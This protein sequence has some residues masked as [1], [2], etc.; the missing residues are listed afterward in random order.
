MSDETIALAEDKT[1]AI[2]TNITHRL[3]LTTDSVFKTPKDEY[4]IP[5]IHNPIG[6]G[7]ESQVYLANR[8]SDNAQV[9]IKIYDA[10]TDDPQIR[11]N[12]KA[13]LE[14]LH[15][16]SDYKNTHIMPL[17]DDG[18]VIMFDDDGDEYTRQFD[19]LPYC[20]E[21]ELKECDYQMLKTQVIP[22]III[23]LNLLHTNNL[24]HRDIKPSNIYMYDGVIL[25]AD[26]GT[27]SKIMN[28]E[29][30]SVTQTKRGTPGY[31]APELSDKYYV[32]ASDYYSLGCTIATL[33]NKGKHV[34]HTFLD[35]RDYDNVTITMRQSGL[36]LSCPEG[37]ADLQLLVDALVM[38]DEKMR[39]GY[40]AVNLWLSNASDFIKKWKNTVQKGF[41][42]P[43]LNFP[44]EDIIC[45][46]YQELTEQILKN[47]E[48]GKRYLYG[49]TFKGFFDKE[50][51]SLAIKAL[52]IIDNPDTAQNH[53]LGLAQFLHYMNTTESSKC[54]IYWC[55]DT[56][57]KLSDISIAI[58]TEKADQQKLI[59]MLQSKFLS[60]KFQNTEPK[61]NEI[62]NAL[63]EIEDIASQHS[64]LGYYLLMFSLAP[65]KDKQIKT[66]DD[67][68]KELTKNGKD[69]YTEA[70]R[71]LSDER[72]FAYLISK[73]FKDAV[74]TLKNNLS[75][76]FITD[77]GTSNLLL[78]YKLF[79][80]IC[81]DKLSVREHY[82]KYGPQAYLYWFQQNLSLYKY[83]S[84]ETQRTEQ[85]IKGV[86]I[87]RD[88]SIDELEKAL[89]SL[90]TFTKNDFLSKFQNNYLL[91]QLG[92]STDN[93]TSG[94]N[95]DN[96]FAFWVGDF[97]GIN[98]PVG[99]LKSIG[100]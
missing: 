41:D 66:A 7:G 85:N 70:Q 39:A 63:L 99:Y 31:T 80:G 77:E 8:T 100:M 81:K 74:L 25:L 60:W 3:K 36:P 50:N 67:I 92:L 33:Y 17:F 59:A 90:R 22:Q 46:T 61:Q 94:I 45:T 87:S 55:G 15:S 16:N 20:K 82:L 96:T 65:D 1:Q 6:T 86:K 10:I 75:K 71:L 73:G 89:M 43:S 5:D 2:D 54:P 30:H 58:S 97:F 93:D 37:E 19:V 24:V 57:E 44:F 11:K 29:S 53:E 14:F 79:E 83:H 98:V 23:A 42:K 69:W 62:I 21:G 13:I 49:G 38:R 52:D 34:Y 40:D 76:K 84:P 27:T 95:T 91:T 28:I 35:A 88:I 47:W 32:I 12:R 78:I 9:V 68:F 64:V 26:F 18:S 72:T 56:Y 4:T 51:A 48:R